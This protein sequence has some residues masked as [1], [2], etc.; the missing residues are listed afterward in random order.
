[1]QAMTTGSN[2]INLP[3]SGEILCT[4]PGTRWLPVFRGVFLRAHCQ[5]DS[6]NGNS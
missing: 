3:P 1:M 6:K 4:A 5:P 2:D